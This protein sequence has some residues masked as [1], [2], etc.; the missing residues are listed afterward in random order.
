VTQPKDSRN[1][2]PVSAGAYGVLQE[3]MSELAYMVRMFPTK[4]IRTGVEKVIEMCAQDNAP[5]QACADMDGKL[6]LLAAT[7]GVFEVAKI[8]LDK[9]VEEY[10]AW[11]DT[12]PQAKQKSGLYVPPSAGKV[13][14]TDA[15]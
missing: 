7:V 11:V 6:K 4:I 5:K 10:R 3:Q 15:E 9:A 8:G 2:I 12:H 1:P 14:L 13:V